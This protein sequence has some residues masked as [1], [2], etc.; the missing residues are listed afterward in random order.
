MDAPERLLNICAAIA[1]SLDQNVSLGVSATNGDCFFDSVV[2][3]LKTDANCGTLT[4]GD[5]RQAV[6]NLFSDETALVYL[7]TWKALYEGAWYESST[8]DKQYYQFIDPVVMYLPVTDVTRGLYRETQQWLS[9]LDEALESFPEDEVLCHDRARASYK[10]ESISDYMKDNEAKICRKSALSQFRAVVVRPKF[11]AEELSIRETTRGVAALMRE[12]FVIIIVSIDSQT[13]QV[14]Y[15]PIRSD[16]SRKAVDKGRCIYVFY[17]K[18]HY[19]PLRI[20]GKR[21]HD[22]SDLPDHVFKAVGRE[23]DLRVSDS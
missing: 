10:L 22:V 17:D 11:W 21:V 3:L 13:N 9:D 7:E 23:D 8:T 1:T 5:L 18:S 15:N 20:D 2:T 19:R 16:D 12:L 6:S 14:Q 4:V